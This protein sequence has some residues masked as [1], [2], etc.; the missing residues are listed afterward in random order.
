[1]KTIFLPEAL[2]PRVLVF[3]MLDQLV[4]LYQVC[5]NCTSGAKKGLAPMGHMFNLGL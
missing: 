5:S 3:G 4:D 1:M 2:R